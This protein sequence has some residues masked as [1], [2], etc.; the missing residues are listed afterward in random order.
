MPQIGNASEG[1]H[2]GAI[3]GFLRGRTTQILETAELPACPIAT[4]WRRLL[5]LE[6]P[7]RV[8]GDRHVRTGMLKSSV[9]ERLGGLIAF[10]PFVHRDLERLGVPAGFFASAG[11]SN[12]RD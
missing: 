1:C 2:L 7:E 12:T 5:G 4:C 8:G 3:I 10:R 6:D 11:L 9:P